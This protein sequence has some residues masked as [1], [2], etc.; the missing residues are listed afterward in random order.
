[1]LL[2]ITSLQPPATD[3]GYL[4]HKHPDRAQTFTLTFGRAHVLYPVAMHERCTAALLL[5]VDPVSLA[6]RAQRGEG[7]GA[8]SDSYVNDRPYV[9]SSF[10]SVAI[11]QVFG[12]A[13][14]GRCGER[15]ELVDASL[16]LEA[17]VAALPCR[18]GEGLVRRLFEPLGYA[19]SVRDHPLDEA[20]PAWGRSPY[21]MVG[22]SAAC[23]L[24]DL[25]AHLY[26]LLPVL[27]D[28]KHYWVGDDEVDKLLRH[29][30]RWLA[31][32]PE[33]ELIVSRYLK[34]QRRLTRQAL[35]RLLEEDQPDPDAEEAAHAREEQEVEARTGLH[36][37]RLAQVAM[38][39]KEHGAERVL[40]LG[41]GE[42]RL[43]RVL[44]H[45]RAFKE[46]VG[47][48]VSVRALESAARRLHLDRAPTG[49]Q[50][51]V[52]LLHGSLTYRDRRL[53]G[54]DAAA[55]I[56]VVEHLEP[57]RLAAFE[58]ALFEFAKPRVV[59]L[60]TPN[61]EYNV[62]FESLPAGRLRHADHRFEWT[63]ADF[64]A[65]TARIGRRFGYTAQIL[66]V[67]PE[68]PLVGAPTQMAVMIRG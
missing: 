2:T 67:G 13:L 16:S 12:S 57:S 51:R 42:G 62:K 59:V 35:S 31:A 45:D 60:T 15:P 24:R 61:A 4:L 23:R 22:L 34:H 25:L 20:F 10:L 58:R 33:R 36:E 65:W 11:S 63:R 29:G 14:A 44:M 41:C 17:D 56:E 52:R 47:M 39:L 27:D 32:H 9:A 6:R 43:L 54:F 7:A 21:L 38:V 53:S 50:N 1:M 48:D 18:G 64:E 8:L 30:E 46:I 26:V 3:L 55:V 49:Q 68:D 5:D 66:P 28:E 19:L 37:R 40:D